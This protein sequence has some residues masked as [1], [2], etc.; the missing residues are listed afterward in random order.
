MKPETKVRLVRMTDPYPV[1]VGTV[2]IVEGVDA[3]GDF[4]VSWSN[5]ST[6][7]LIKDI[8]EWEV[9]NE[10]GSALPVLVFSSHRSG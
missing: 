2:G 6:L 3:L 9:L 7:K 10:E 5:G 4:L 8:D 1:P